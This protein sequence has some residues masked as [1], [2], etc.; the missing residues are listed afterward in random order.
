MCS[1]VASTI[2]LRG[3]QHV[4]ATM[5][6]SVEMA[7]FWGAIPCLPAIYCHDHIVKESP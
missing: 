6:M 3:W 1:C 4:M 2:D 5:G 7:S